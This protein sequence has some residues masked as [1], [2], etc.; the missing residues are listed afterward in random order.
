MPLAAGVAASCMAAGGMRRTRSLLPVSCVRSGSGR[1]WR[2][3]TW[4]Q[5]DE[6]SFFRFGLEI[7][8]CILYIRF[9]RVNSPEGSRYIRLD[10]LYVAAMWACWSMTK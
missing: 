6:Y 4:D 5:Q 9:V 7:S 10:R 3:N 8:V 2:L 1:G